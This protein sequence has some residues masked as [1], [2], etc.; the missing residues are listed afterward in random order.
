MNTKPNSYKTCPAYIIPHWNS[1]KNLVKSYTKNSSTDN[2]STVVPPQ[3]NTNKKEE[4]KELYRVRK[5]WNDA[6]SQI[7]AYSI[8]DNAKN[9][10]PT[11]YSVFDSN[12]KV[13]F[14][15]NQQI[16]TSPNNNEK[17]DIVYQVYTNK[18]LPEVTN[19]NI[20][21]SDGY[22]GII[23][24]PIRGVAI[25]SLKGNVKYRVHIKNGGWLSWINQ[26]NINDLS[27]VYTGLKT[28]NIDAIQID[29]EGLDD[30]IVKYRV[31]TTNSTNYLD[32]VTG[33]NNIDSN[34]Y[35][36]IFGKTIERLQISIEKK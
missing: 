3:E 34:G 9:N 36:G 25:K 12:G 28:K 30:Y 5:N 19:Y 1:F 18:W 15:N 10:C 4:T 29:L 33:Y 32:W 11:G 16:N 27:K 21:N 14:T 23:G 6:S 26:Y 24:Q 2:S 13:V 17:I 20:K 8:L 31:C 35:A 7:G 22:A